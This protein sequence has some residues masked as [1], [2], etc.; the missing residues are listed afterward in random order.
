MAAAAVATWI[1]I[2]TETGT[3][4]VSVPTTITMTLFVTRALLQVHD[5][6]GSNICVADK[7]APVITK[8]KIHH[9]SQ[10]GVYDI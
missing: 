6:I 3:E 4:T 1:G 7:S 2:V 5:N 8:N 10:Y 9:S